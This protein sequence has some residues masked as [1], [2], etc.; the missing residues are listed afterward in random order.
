MSGWWLERTSAQA[1]RLKRRYAALR[2]IANLYHESLATRHCFI[3]SQIFH[4]PLGS[5]FRLSLHCTLVRS[6]P[7]LLPLNRALPDD[8]T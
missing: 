2:Y 4:T 1:N 7:C 8:E 3:R 6:R 5:T